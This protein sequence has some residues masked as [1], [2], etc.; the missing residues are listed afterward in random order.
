MK[1][2]VEFADFNK[3]A[4]KFFGNEERDIVEFLSSNLVVAKTRKFRLNS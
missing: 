3:K 2:V 4:E 1:T